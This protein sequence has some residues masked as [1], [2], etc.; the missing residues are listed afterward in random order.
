MSSDF[1]FIIIGAGSAGCVLADKLSE[2]GEYKVLL[3][4]AG[5]SD[6]NFWIKMPIGY[7][8]NFTNKSINWCYN[9]DPE[10]NLNNRAIFMPRG[11]VLGGSSSINALV[12]HRGQSKDYNDW[13]AEGNYEW[14]Y[15]N[16]KQ[17]FNSFENFK[18]KNNPKV[19]NNKNSLPVNNVWKDYHSLK[20]VFLDCCMQSQFPTS[21]LGFI[22]G[23]GIGPYLITTKKGKRFSSADS[24]L[25]PSLKRPNLKLFTNTLV[26]KII[27]KNH[28]AVGVEL[29]K[30]KSVK[31]KQHFTIEAKKEVL[32]CAGAI[33]SPQLL[34]LS[35]IGDRQLLEKHQ[36][37]TVLD[38]PNVGKHL[39]DHLGINYYSKAKI[40]TLND[41]LG[42]WSGLLKSGV[43]YIFRGT[44]PLSLGVNQIGGL[45]KSSASEKNAD[46]Q[47][48]LNP[49]SYTLRKGNVRQLTKPDKYSGFFL[50]FNSCRPESRGE[51]NIQSN[52]PE[53]PPKIICNY[54]SHNK[55]IQDIIK[56]AR[57]IARLQETEAIKRLLKE[58]PFTPL[59]N[60][61]DDE[62]IYDFQN[63]SGTV[64]HPCGTCKMGSDPATSVVDSKLNVH[65]I[66]NLRVVDASIFPNIT[67]ANTNSPTIMIAHKAADM[68]LEN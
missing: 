40:P 7:G 28:R 58:P 53:K 66:S 51:V 2:T 21:K 32:L 47:L 55:D 45:V 62:I 64:F 34:Q 8:I 22:E 20:N 41:I 23:E 5:P 61:T 35:G 63:R 65:N 50:S 9:T 6:K 38:Q 4:E 24:F 12:Y 30:R 68:I 27:I 16:L 57:L 36:I 52:D 19:K 54:L 42:N 39:Q 60:M 44:G 13:A 1:D 67:S 29:F 26:R 59:S 33:N 43:E 56:G 11:K 18:D 46:M 25:K 10:K 17:Y 3:I 15:D 37:Q 14:G 49:V 48:Y 31:E